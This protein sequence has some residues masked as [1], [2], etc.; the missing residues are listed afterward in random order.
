VFAVHFGPAHGVQHDVC[1]IHNSVA[2][3]GVGRQPVV[4]NG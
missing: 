4:V 3:L 1:G 2:S